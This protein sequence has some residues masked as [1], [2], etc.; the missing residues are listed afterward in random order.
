MGG[1]VS[2]PLFNHYSLRGDQKLSHITLW[3]FRGSWGTRL[4]R[5]IIKVASFCTYVFRIYSL[6][7]C[8]YMS[9]YNFLLDS[10][11]P[12]FHFLS[13]FKISKFSCLEVSN[14]LILVKP[15]QT[16][17]S[18]PM[19]EQTSFPIIFCKTSRDWP[20]IILL[21]LGNIPTAGV[22]AKLLISSHFDSKALNFTR[23]FSGFRG[24]KHVLDFTGVVFKVF[25]LFRVSV[26]GDSWP[27]NCLLFVDAVLTLVGVVIFILARLL[28]LGCFLFFW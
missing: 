10:S 19:A 11:C 22:K 7:K 9:V 25:S 15:H 26:L 23:G 13:K 28:G 20:S 27:L 2:L 12:N 18:R 1:G 16:Q 5:K 6:L 24:N 21:D 8:Y 3:G 17:F 14:W 4:L